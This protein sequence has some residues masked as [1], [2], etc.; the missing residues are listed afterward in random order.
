MRANIKEEA[1]T[2]YWDLLTCGRLEG[3]YQVTMDY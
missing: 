2:G 3:W 1:D